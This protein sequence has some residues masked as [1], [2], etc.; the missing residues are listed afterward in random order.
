MHSKLGWG[1]S[2]ILAIVLIA[3]IGYFVSP[4]IKLSGLKSALEARNPQAVKLYV[5][6]SRLKANVK[7]AEHKKV[8]RSNKGSLLA[9]VKDKIVNTIADYKLDQLASPEGLIHLVCDAKPDGSVDSSVPNSAPCTLKGHLSGFSFL[10]PNR[11]RAIVT[12]NHGKDF[13]MIFARYGGL[14]WQL[15]NLQYR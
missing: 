6:F 2:A 10:A 13:D 11:F 15:I 4:L 3:L 7:H 9:P 5:D 14:H 12:P 1:L 8:N